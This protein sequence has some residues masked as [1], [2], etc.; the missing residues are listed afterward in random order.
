[1]QVGLRS[2]VD[3][4]R[5][6]RE[7]ERRSRV[8]VLVLPVAF[9]AVLASSPARAHDPSA[10][11]GLFR[12][13]DAGATWFLASPGRLA[14]AAI[15]LAISPTDVNHLLLASDNG[16]LR[17]RNGGRDWVL[18]APTV[19]V[20][21]VFA[22]A[23][24]E[25][26]Q[27]ALLSTGTGLFRSSRENDWRP[28]PAPAGAVPARAIVRGSDAGRVYV[29]GSAGLFHSDDWGVSWSDAAGGL[30]DR[31]VTALVVTP[32]RPGRVYVIAGGQIWERTDSERVW[33]K[34]SAAIPAMDALALDGSDAARLWAAGANLIFRSDDHGASWRPVGVPLPEANTAVRGIAASG[35]VVV[36]ATDR[37]LYRTADGGERWQPLVDNLPAHLEAGPLVCDPVDPATLYA[38]FALTPYPELWRRAAEGGTALGRVNVISLVGGVLFLT[39]MAWTTVVAVRR[40]RRYYGPPGQDVSTTLP[41]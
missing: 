17:S 30:P 38:G 3:R 6:S 39:L 10:W 34:P 7:R 4:R 16:L 19:L 1:M 23:F 15:A 40:V 13:R 5:R 35:A 32:S 25:D 22:V 29:A 8:S 31:P 37:G 21:P 33:T 11:G 36:L 2:D 9:A 27:Q 26:G 12:S 28:T 14:S 18:E 41:P 20:G 24:S